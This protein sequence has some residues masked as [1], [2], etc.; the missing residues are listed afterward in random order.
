MWDVKARDLKSLP[1]ETL[2]ALQKKLLLESPTACGRWRG[3]HRRNVLIL[4]QHALP[5]RQ[6]AFERSAE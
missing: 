5:S 1:V 2:V 6:E 4:D 3:Q